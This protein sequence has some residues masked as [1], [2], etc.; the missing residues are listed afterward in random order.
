MDLER[1][2]ISDVISVSFDKHACEPLN[3]RFT[4]PMLNPLTK[5]A[6]SGPGLYLI[7]FG[8][9][10]IYIGKYQPFDRGNILNDRWLRHLETITLRGTRVGFGGKRKPENRLKRLL[11][12][13]RHPDLRSHLELIYE[14]YR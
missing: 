12:H 14:N 5:A 7:S 4:A 2:H 11:Q 1:L 8:G 13:V 3:L 9:E 10:V 6:W